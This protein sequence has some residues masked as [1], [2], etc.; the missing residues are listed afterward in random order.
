MCE[1]AL[2]DVAL[3]E[4]M[5]LERDGGPRL[6]RKRGP[7]RD[8]L[9]EEPLVGPVGFQKRCPGQMSGPASGVFARF[10]AKTAGCGPSIRSPI[11]HSIY[12]LAEDFLAELD[13]LRR[14]RGS[15]TAHC[16]IFS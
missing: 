14:C 1:G 3:H 10:L 2:D 8:S 15:D 4:P 16:S 5:P 7:R 11:D 9:L 12:V 13:V 6:L